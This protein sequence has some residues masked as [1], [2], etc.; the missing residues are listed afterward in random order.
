MV[1][2]AAVVG[3]HDVLDLVGQ[4]AGRIDLARRRRPEQEGDLATVADRLVGEHPHA[5]HP[6]P[7]GDEQ[8][9][10]AARVHL[11]RPAERPEEVDRVARPQPGEPVG[12]TA[13][14]PE[15]DR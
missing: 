5:G 12:P 10:P 2:E 13:D 7:A 1:T 3:R 11:E 15:M 8:Q 9:V 6:E 14:D 4:E